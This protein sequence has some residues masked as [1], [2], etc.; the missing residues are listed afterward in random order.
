MGLN[1]SSMYLSNSVGNC[2][3]T[4]L[5]VC[6]SFPW[7][8]LQWSHHHQIL[9]S[10]DFPVMPFTVKRS[11]MYQFET[12]HFSVYWPMELWYFY[13]KQS[14][15]LMAKEFLHFG[16][17]CFL[18]LQSCF[19]ISQSSRSCENSFCWFLVCMFWAR[20]SWACLHW[21]GSWDVPWSPKAACCLADNAL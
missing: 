11:C 13:K 21:A 4:S 5:F 16:V 6:S 3:S 7:Q 15:S 12:L 20:S 8:E 9:V 18:P 2:I 1:S 17:F 14:N 10:S 19:M